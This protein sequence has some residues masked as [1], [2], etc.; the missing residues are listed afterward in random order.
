MRRKSKIAICLNDGILSDID[1]RIDGSTLTSR[2]QAIEF[3]LRRGLRS[4]SADTAVIM[5]KGSHQQLSARLIHGKPLLLRQLSFLSEYGIRNIFIST[6]ETGLR[7]FEASARGFAAELGLNLRVVT[8]D[9]HGTGEAVYSLN[10][11]I[12]QDFVVMSGDVLNCFDLRKMMRKHF[13]VGRIA[14]MGL[15]TRDRPSEYGSAVLEGD[16][17]ISFREKPREYDSFVVNAG[18]Y[19]FKPSVFRFLGGKKS[20]ERELFPQL[21]RERELVGFFTHGEYVHMPESD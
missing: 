11:L 13:E 12:E 5:I 14:T 7:S 3:F 4:L 9:S 21:A 15:M 1:S 8:S 10:S 6:H 18:V 19:I 16:L 17:I 20:L 2:S